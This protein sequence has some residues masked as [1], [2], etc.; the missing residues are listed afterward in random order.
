VNGHANIVWYQEIE[1]VGQADGQQIGDRGGNDRSS[2]PA[3]PP[4]EPR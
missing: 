3:R 1:F 2:D 4:Y